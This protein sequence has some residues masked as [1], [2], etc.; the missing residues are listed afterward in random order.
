[1]LKNTAGGQDVLEI[2]GE[3][4]EGYHVKVCRDWRGWKEEKTDFM[5]KALFE[6]CLRTSYLTA[7]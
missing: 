5:P 6:S 7:C 1:M 3:S 4:E 2:L